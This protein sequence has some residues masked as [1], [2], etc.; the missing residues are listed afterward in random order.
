MAI[1]TPT[2]IR[3]MPPPVI[4]TRPSRMQS[5]PLHPEMAAEHDRFL[6][7]LPELMKTIPGKHVALRDGQILAVADDEVSALTAARRVRPGVMI[8]A[9]LVTDQPIPVERLPILRPAAP[10]SE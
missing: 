3:R 6:A 5:R 1:E 2:P 9:R 10:E 4:P 7:M 8:L